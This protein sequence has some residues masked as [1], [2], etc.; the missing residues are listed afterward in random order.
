VK[1]GSED[2][3]ISHCCV[4]DNGVTNYLNIPDQ[5]GV[6][7]NISEDPLYA[8]SF[9][10]LSQTAAGQL[11]QSPAVDAGHGSASGLVIAGLSTRTDSI[12]DSGVA[13][14]GFH[15]GPP[16][17]SSGPGG[18]SPSGFGLDV[19]PCPSSGAVVLRVSV[20]GP[21]M[22]EISVWDA[23]GRRIAVLPGLLF[24]GVVDI[25][26]EIPSSVP[27]GL[28]FFRMSTENRSANSRLVYIP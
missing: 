10:R 12:P 24:E 25:P 17:T 8:D 6:L 11:L 15:Y 7:G 5:T 1:V 9:R 18:A 27:A 14:M 13:D 22:V 2:Y 4:W 26:W 3:L 23:G 28:L 21:S 16:D 20:T 19:F